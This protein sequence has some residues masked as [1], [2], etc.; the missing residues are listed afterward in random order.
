MM[1]QFDLKN[2][3]LSSY[4]HFKKLFFADDYTNY[5]K[6]C[7]DEWTNKNQIYVYLNKQMPQVVWLQIQQR[8]I[9]LSFEVEESKC[10]PRILPIVL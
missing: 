6:C 8:K 10:L 9:G 1:K 4:C 5:T 2:L 7:G 3:G